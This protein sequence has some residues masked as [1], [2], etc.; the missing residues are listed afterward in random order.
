MSNESKTLIILTPGFPKDEADSTCLPFLQTFIR[1]V[2]RVDPS[3]NIIVL[4]FQ[5][6]HFSKEYFWEGNKVISFNGRNKGKIYRLL[7]WIKILKKIKKLTHENNVIGFFNLWLGEC[8]LIGKYASKKYR[9]KSFTWILGQDAKTNNGYIKFIKP[10]SQSLIAMSDFLADNFEKNFKVRPAHII[11]LGI[12]KNL[13]TE[14]LTERNIDILGAGSLIPLKQYDVF[15]KMVIKLAQKRPGIK[16][17]ILGEGKERETLQK[18]ID[19]NKMSNNIR[20]AGDTAHKETLALMQRSKIFLHPSSYEGF[21]TVCAEALYA[22]AKLISFVK[23]MNKEFKNWFIVETEVDMLKQLETILNDPN[24]EYERVMVY[25]SE[26]IG[27][28]VLSLYNA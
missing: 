20:L 3:L 28:E 10:N 2:N 25:D 19:E 21:G 5:Y 15:I 17:V 8:A 27:R 12:D 6:P 18:M 13:F 14:P 1:S 7:L 11:P 24:P 26:A 16:T 4:A 23:P 22:G 9:I